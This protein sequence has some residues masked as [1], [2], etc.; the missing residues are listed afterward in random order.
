MLNG[1]FGGFINWRLT[2]LRTCSI[3][4]FLLRERRFGMPRLRF[5][6]SSLLVLSTSL[7]LTTAALAQEHDHGPST[8]HHAKPAKLMHMKIAPAKIVSFP[9]AVAGNASGYL[10]I[11]SGKAGTKYPALVVIQ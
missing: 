4:F 10:A 6:L 8:V 11:P 5:L 1:E 9:S 7:F 2:L 3:V